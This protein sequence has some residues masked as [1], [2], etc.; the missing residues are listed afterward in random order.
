[1]EKMGQGWRKIYVKQDTRAIQTMFRRMEK[2]I[3]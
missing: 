1:M 3:I 2:I